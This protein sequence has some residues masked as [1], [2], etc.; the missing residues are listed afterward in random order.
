MSL[1]SFSISWELSINRAR[2]KR[3]NERE[4][5][6]LRVLCA[7]VGEND[8][9]RQAQFVTPTEIP[10]RSAFVESHPC[11]QNAQEWGTH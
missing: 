10:K 9:Q 11:A 2:N 6:L 3:I 5:P 7:R 1:A 8:H 4:S